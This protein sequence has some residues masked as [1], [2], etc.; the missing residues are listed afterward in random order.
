[1]KFIDLYKVLGIQ[2]N[3]NSEQIKQAYRRMARMTHPDV[4]GDGDEMKLVNLAYEV[5]YD[6]KSR[7]EYNQLYNEFFKVSKQNPTRLREN[8]ISDIEKSLYYLLNKKNKTLYAIINGSLGILIFGILFLISLIAASVDNPTSSTPVYLK[9]IYIITTIV[10]GTVLFLFTRYIYKALSKP[11]FLKTNKV[12]NVS[13]SKNEFISLDDIKEAKYH[14]I[15]LWLLITIIFL[16]ILVV[17]V[18]TILSI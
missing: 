2:S 6:Q 17:F 3:A 9:I 8:E 4:G 11:S 12:I 5:L 1:M 10:A 14:N 7:T 18:K 15:G 16:L 13:E